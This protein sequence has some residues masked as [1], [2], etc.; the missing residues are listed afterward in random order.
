MKTPSLL[1]L[2]LV[3]VSITFSPRANT[4][5]ASEAYKR[6]QLSNLNGLEDSAY[7]KS[8]KGDIEGTTP[9][10]EKTI[11][12]E[13][14]EAVKSAYS[15]GSIDKLKALAEKGDTDAM[16][17]LG[18]Y[19]EKHKDKAAAHAWYRNAADAGNEDAKLLQGHLE[20]RIKIMQSCGIYG[21]NLSI[22]GDL[23]KSGYTT[24][25]NMTPEEEEKA[26]SIYID[27]LRNEIM[28]DTTAN[29][30]DDKEV[31]EIPVATQGSNDLIPQKEV[32]IMEI[33]AEKNK[34][35]SINEIDCNEVTRSCRL[36]TLNHGESGFTPKKE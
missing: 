25:S 30:K 36:Q 9:K 16:T 22:S 10:D 26:E 15:D 29:I 34:V 28:G 4:D 23:E 2:S 14:K 7:Y 17:E 33:N 8:L 12:A 27:I 31:N 24:K 1:S 19:Y 3:A 32:N 13:R 18:L 21:C 5:D 20:G 35:E 6:S 11:R